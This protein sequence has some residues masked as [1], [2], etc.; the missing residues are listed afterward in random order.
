MLLYKR[1]DVFVALNFIV[2]DLPKELKQNNFIIHRPPISKTK[3][4]HYLHKK[5]KELTPALTQALSQIVG[6]PIKPLD[7]I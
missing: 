7:D 3:F 4:Y 2:S 1:I 5:H 6:K